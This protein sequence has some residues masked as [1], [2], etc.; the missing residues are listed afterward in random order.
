[1]N[2]KLFRKHIIRHVRK[3]TFGHMRPAEIQIS[4]RIRAVWSES[5]LG[6]IWIAKDKILWGQQKLWSDWAHMSDSALSHTAPQSLTNF[7]FD[8]LLCNGIHK[9][10]KAKLSIS[11]LYSGNSG[12]NIRSKLPLTLQDQCNIIDFYIVPGKYPR[13]RVFYFISRQLNA[14]PVS[15][16]ESCHEKKGLILCK[17]LCSEGPAQHAHCANWSESFISAYRINIELGRAKRKRVFEH[18]QTTQIQIH[19]AHAQSL[20]RTFALHWYIL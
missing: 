1:M 4:L 8:T 15:I 5:S 13:M 17:V 3:G 19:T 14:L 7:Y 11:C 6:A 2:C 16:L 18:A 20:I 10:R 9:A 12:A